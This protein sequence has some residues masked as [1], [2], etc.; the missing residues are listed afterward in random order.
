ML[1]I[2]QFL[3]M[4]IFVI[5]QFAFNMQYSEF[6]TSAG[7][8]ALE[9]VIYRAT[10]HNFMALILKWETSWEEA[11]TKWRHGEYYTV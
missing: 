9:S 5:Y 2:I 10:K 4:N 1:L 8:Y 6:I 7:F 3:V 11:G